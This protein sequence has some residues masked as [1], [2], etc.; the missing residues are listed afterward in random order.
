MKVE[1][2]LTKNLN[3][4]NLT[5]YLRFYQNFLNKKNYFFKKNFLQFFFKS[6]NYLYSYYFSVKVKNFYKISWNFFSNYTVKNFFKL[7]YSK[8]Q[9][10]KKI[11]FLPYFLKFKGLKLGVSGKNCSHQPTT[12][13]NNFSKIIFFLSF[14]IN[15]YNVLFFLLKNKKFLYFF[16]NL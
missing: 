4:N 16:K 9:N 1:K 10:F 2:F 15:Y 3:I 11:I 14:T 7:K 5:I 13:F 12:H 6:L 8:P